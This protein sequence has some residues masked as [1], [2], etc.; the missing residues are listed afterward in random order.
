MAREQF[1]K[2]GFQPGAALV[3]MADTGVK[4]L[5]GRRKDLAG[6]GSR[7]DRHDGRG[8][9]RSAAA[10]GDPAVADLLK[11]RVE[12]MIRLQKEMLEAAKGTRRAR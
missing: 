4:Q 7:R 3:E 10:A 8:R 6:F 5:H 9:E 12:T 1:G 11:H 2:D